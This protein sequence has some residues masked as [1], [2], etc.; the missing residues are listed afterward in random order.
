MDIK[1][2]LIC[3]LFFIGCY[4][5]EEVFTPDLT[6][7]YN[8]KLFLD[9]LDENMLSLIIDTRKESGIIRLD[10][11]FFIKLNYNSLRNTANNSIEGLINIKF[12]ALHKNKIGLALAP[13]LTTNGNIKNPKQLFFIQILKDGEVL[14][15]IEPI[16]VFVEDS[17]LD[18][19]NLQFYTNKMGDGHN[20]WAELKEQTHAYKETLSVGGQAIPFDG[21][22]ISLNLTNDI[23]LA[24]EEP[25]QDIQELAA[26]ICVTTNLHSNSKNSLVLFFPENYFGLYNLTEIVER[27]ETFCYKGNIISSSNKGKIIVISQFSEGNF[28]FGM[29]DA[30]LN[31]DQSIKIETKPTS[32]KDIKVLLAKL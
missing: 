28:H 23:W 14:N 22:K 32:I 9:Q 16:D 30:V 18:K 19:T 29:K 12:A 25:R 21:Y 31:Q 3:F 20:T 11:N 27:S 5:N 15:S 24:V 8:K 4:K 17:H 6:N 1:L 10:Q 2:L 13:S 7:I 26:Q